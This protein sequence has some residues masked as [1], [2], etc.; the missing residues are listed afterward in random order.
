METSLKG[1]EIVCVKKLAALFEAN[2]STWRSQEWSELGLDGNNYSQVLSLMESIGA[3]TGVIH[4]T[5]G[6]F[7]YFTIDVNA[8]QIARQIE[9]QEEKDNE[10]K[11]IVE[12][13]RLTLR[14]HPVTAWG[15]IIGVGLM[16]LIAAANQIITFLRAIGII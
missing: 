1:S 11:D 6:R 15:T 10:R 8:V 14:K 13:F 3:I 9:R 7:F 2:K 16:A 4:T 12:L 5:G